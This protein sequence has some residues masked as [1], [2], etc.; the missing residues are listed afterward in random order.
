[1]DDRYKGYDG[2]EQLPGADDYY[3]DQYRQQISEYSAMDNTDYFNSNV[4]FEFE[5]YPPQN[6]AGYSQP[7]QRQ[8]AARREYIHP[9]RAANQN[10]NA[11]R[12]ARPAQNILNSFFIRRYFIKYSIAFLVIIST[13][14]W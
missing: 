3:A 2:D 1:M 7:P 14:L 9:K 13:F 12:N 10:R 8:P 6:D 4:D 5:Q 11:Q